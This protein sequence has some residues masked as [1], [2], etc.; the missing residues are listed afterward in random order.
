M[1]RQTQFIGLTRSAMDFIA[2]YKRVVDLSHVTHGM[3][4]E[5]IGLGTWV[6]ESGCQKFWKIREVVQAAPWSSGPM[7][8]TCL[9]GYFHNDPEHKN[10]VRMLEWVHDPRIESEFD[11]E[12]GL[13]WV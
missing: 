4:D 5:E 10:A 6:D 1:S 12:K 3:F 7:I 2:D 13:F 11:V 9:D 8:F